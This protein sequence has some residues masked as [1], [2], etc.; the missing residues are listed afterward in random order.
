MGAPSQPEQGSVLITGVA[1]NLASRLLLQMTGT[2]VV[3]VDL[4]A[5]ASD[6]GIARFESV[7]LGD[8][9]CCAQSIRTM[10]GRMFEQ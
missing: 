2:R 4:H 1:G 10:R 7:D 9:A 6:A 5:P 3:G 8:E